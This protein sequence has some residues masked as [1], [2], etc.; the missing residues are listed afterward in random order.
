MIY[1]GKDHDRSA[2]RL[3]RRRYRVFDED[4]DIHD[5]GQVEWALGTRFQADT[6]MVVLTGMIGMTMGPSL[7]GRRT[8]AKAGFDCTKPFGRDGEIPLTRSAAKRFTGAP[9]FRSVEEALAA[10]AAFYA[11]LVEGVGSKDGR[12]VAAALDALRQ[13]G[14]LVRDRDGR[15]ALGRSQPGVTGIAGALYPDPNEGT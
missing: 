1:G 10:G 14:R 8:G 13:Q 3:R 15:Y 2:A 6:D 5:E 11:D 9:R 7:Q 12:E 4:I